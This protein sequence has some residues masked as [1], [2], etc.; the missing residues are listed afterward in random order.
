ML[1]QGCNWCLWQMHQLV[2]W[3]ESEEVNGHVRSQII[4]Q[5]GR[6]LS[7]LAQVFSYLRNNE[8]CYLCMNP[9]FIPDV[10]EGL[11]DR[12]RVRDH[13]MLPQEPGLCVTLEVY[14]YT[15]QKIVHH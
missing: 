5:P 12:L 9:S 14:S 6:E 10:Q 3:M 8:V 4:I 13:Y 15:I 1:F 2:V 11:K 7:S